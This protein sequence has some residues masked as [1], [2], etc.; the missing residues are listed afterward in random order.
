MAKWVAPWQNPWQIMIPTRERLEALVT[1]H[2]GSLE[3]VPFAVLLCALAVRRQTAVLELQRHQI[4]KR[5]VVELGTPVDCRSN[6]VHETLGRFLVAKGVITEEQD[7]ETLNEAANH[8]VPQGEVLRAHRLIDAYGLYRVLQENLAKKL[9]DAFSWREGQYRLAFDVPEVHSPLKVKVPQLVVTGVSRFSTREEVVAGISPLIGQTLQ[10]HPEPWFPL[11]EIK[12]TPS[13]LELARALRQPRRIDELM[14]T[15]GLEDDVLMRDLYALG[16]IGAVAPRQSI[17]AAQ[18]DGPPVPITAEE[19]STAPEAAGS[20]TAMDPKVVETLRNEV[21]EAYLAHRRQDA[22]DL[23]GLPEEAAPLEIQARFLDYSQRFAP[24]QFDASPLRAL[25]E[26]A[27]E[28]FLAGALAFSEL[29][30]S[31]QRNAL[32]YRRQVRR[33]GGAPKP[34]EDRFQIKT[35]LL[36]PQLQFRR[37][38]LLLEEGKMLEALKLL[39]FAADCDPQNGAYQA[40]VAYCRYLYSPRV[41]AG[42]ARDELRETLRIDPRCGIA[43]HYLGEILAAQG[44]EAAARRHLQQAASLLPGDPRPTEALQG[45]KG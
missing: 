1:A 24:W 38:R 31:E 37:G 39:S 25:Q 30:D 33:Q 4:T 19:R 41:N 10:L 43:H 45:L 42:K 23:L 11:P 35:D 6:L 22:F 44:D 9:L 34:S 7:Q 3:E 2:E 5:V 20:G 36:D 8:G 16:V 18:R 27:E 12:L 17:P 32:L 15:T 28:L 29:R 14:E 13:Q 26:K 40:E 21:M